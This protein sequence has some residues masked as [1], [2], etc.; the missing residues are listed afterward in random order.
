[1]AGDTR[2]GRAILVLRQRRGWR[3]VDLAAR[4]GV[5]D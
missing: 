1:M 3:Q 2:I 4:A 5:T